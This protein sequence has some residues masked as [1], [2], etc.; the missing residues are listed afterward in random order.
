MAPLI[1]VGCGSRK[2]PGRHRAD[3]L[4]TSTSFR[5]R[6]LYARTATTRD[7]VYILSA[8]HG[9]IRCDKMINKYDVTLGKN[10]L[11]TVQMLRAQ[12]EELGIINEPVVYVIA[13]ISYV[14][15]V[16]GVWPT[17]FNPAYGHVSY[18][19]KGNANLGI[20]TQIGWLNKEIRRLQREQ[21]DRSYDKT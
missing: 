14:N 17:A 16:R 10:S 12:A 1:L 7:K 6:L 5:T 4:Y 18:D 19:K 13:K 15:I 3:E 8:L 2:Q 21:Q 9:I 11:I 20:G